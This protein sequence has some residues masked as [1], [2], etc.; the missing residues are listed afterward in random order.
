MKIRFWEGDRWGKWR[1]CKS[2]KNPGDLYG[3]RK[4]QVKILH[5]NGDK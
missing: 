2:R 5:E 4:Y 1:E 3:N